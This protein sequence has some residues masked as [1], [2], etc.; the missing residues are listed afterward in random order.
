MSEPQSALISADNGESWS[1]E[2]RYVS[3]MIPE[4]A[5]SNV[6]RMLKQRIPARDVG[7]LHSNKLRVFSSDRTRMYSLVFLN[8]WSVSW[9]VIS[10]TTIQG[11]FNESIGAEHMNTEMSSHEIK[12]QDSFVHIVNSDSE[13]EDEA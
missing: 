13:S 7:K 1:Q 10:I 9:T 11:L 6:D 12:N 8:A 5:T 4:S 2:G 3:I